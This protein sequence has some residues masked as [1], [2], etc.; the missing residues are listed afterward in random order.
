MKKIIFL[1]ALVFLVS[2]CVGQTA[3]VS[4]S[5]TDEDLGSHDTQAEE[6][7]ESTETESN[8]VELGVVARQWEFVPNRI[9]VNEGD[10]VI[11][12]VTSI[13]VAHGIRIFEFGV[14]ERLE[15]GETVDIEFVADKKGTFPFVCSVFCGS[16]HGSMTG[17]IVV[18]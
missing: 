15:P 16:G 10:T 11:L 8:V 18:N 9:E 1:F 6:Q 5:I 3:T 13:D 4:E 17:E 14:S 7:T 12:H 2:G